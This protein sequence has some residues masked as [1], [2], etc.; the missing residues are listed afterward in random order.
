MDEFKRFSIPVKWRK[1][2]WLSMMGILMV[3]YKWFALKNAQ[4]EQDLKDCNKG[5]V[6][7]MGNRIKSDSVKLEMFMREALRRAEKDIIQPKID[8]IK[9]NRS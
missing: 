6:E 1:Y 3:P 5:R 7:D 2:V 9:A 8:S 4:L